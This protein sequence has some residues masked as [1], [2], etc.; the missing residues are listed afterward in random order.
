MASTDASFAGPWRLRD[1]RTPLTG[2][3]TPFQYNS[4]DYKDLLAFL[5]LLNSITDRNIKSHDTT[6]TSGH[7]ISE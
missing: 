6:I 2:K 7:H 5:R 1:K 3:P 4:I